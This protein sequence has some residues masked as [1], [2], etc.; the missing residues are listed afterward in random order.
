[1][2]EEMALESDDSS[3]SEEILSTLADILKR[4]E[5]SGT[6]GALDAILKVFGSTVASGLGQESD[7]ARDKP[8]FYF[9]MAVEALENAPQPHK[10]S[11]MLI[12]RLEMAKAL[13]VLGEWDEA[14]AYL[15]DVC[16]AARDAGEKR[17]EAEALREVGRIERR[18]ERWEEALERYRQSET[19]SKE[20][21]DGVGMASASNCIGAVYF[22]KGE[23]KKARIEFED[24]LKIASDLENRKLI[25]QLNNNL[26]AIADVRGDHQEAI[27]LYQ[28][29]LLVFREMDDARGSAEV[30]N[31]MGM[32][33]AVIKEWKTAGRCYEKSLEISLRAGDLE[34]LSDL[35]LNKSD[36]CLTMNQWS[37]ARVY[38]VK[39][40]EAFTSMG[41]RL[42]VAEAHKL[43]GIVADHDEKWEL[44]KS[45]FS[46]SVRINRECGCLLNLA[47]SC[48]DFGYACLRRG[49]SDEG[50]QLLKSSHEIFKQLEARDEEMEVADCLARIDEGG[51]NCD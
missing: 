37:S 4:A 34:L 15:E 27:S 51:A 25:A 38:A 28:K 9:Q 18:R 46:S 45:H 33:Y 48:R 14:V 44:S 11:T 40:L 22:E 24:A 17:L 30:Y 32:S 8:S 3:S 42:G 47:E 35:Y 20:I 21:G 2:D 31:N 12:L 5:Q 29:A 7:P 1:M 16:A 43:L 13:G 6:G 26:A 10:T 36:L 41:D 39:A 50:K 23:M 19:I 49:E